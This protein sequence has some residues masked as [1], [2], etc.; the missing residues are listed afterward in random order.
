MRRCCLLTVAC[1]LASAAIPLRAQVPGPPAAAPVTPNDYA[2]DSTWLCR[3][4]RQDACA[5]DLATTVIKGDGTMT[6]E[7]WRARPDAA[8]DCFYVYPTIST[9]AG[10]NSD[11]TPDPA[12]RNVIA[13]QFA[14]F[15]SV[16]RPFA[17]LYRQVTLAG[18][19]QRLNGSSLDL[20]TGLAYDDVRDAWRNYLT[21]DNRGRGVVLIGHS[22]G[23][24]LLIELLRHEIEGKP[25]EKQIVSAIL[26]GTTIN[27]PKGARTG[28]TFTSL[29]PCRSASDTGCIISFSTYRA[30]IP[31]PAGALFGRHVGGNDAVCT[32][33]ATFD[34][35]AGELHSY[36]S[37]S[38][39]TIVSRPKPE[40]WLAGNTVETP[41]VS[42][43]GLISARC[44]SNEFSTYL[45]ITVRGDPSDPRVDDVTG[46]LGPPG[47]P[48][49]TW[50]LHLVDVNL[51]MGDLVHVVEQQAQAWASRRP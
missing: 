28:G 47:K 6:R 23:S 37:T 27:V 50:G 46:D 33:P 44:T 43:P 4:G 25:V 18:L 19:R 41:W 10:T 34:D 30:T 45:E 15:A 39:V 8:I 48:L 1:V 11:M 35:S 32:N 26:M 51:A 20:G 14:R 38:G 24:Y 12:E 49:A 16:C 2:R 36:L 40:P 17:P 13:Q 29:A 42:V 21:R 7:E 5:I 9:D 22:Q 3:P 31:P